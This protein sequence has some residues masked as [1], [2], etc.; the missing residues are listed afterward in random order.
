MKT[1]ILLGGATGIL[2]LLVS[3]LLATYGSDGT[4][5]LI[6]VWIGYPGG[7]A[8]WKLNPPHV[9]YALITAVN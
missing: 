7:F 8:N 2:A 6:A 9:S 3:F 5:G 1:H 4:L